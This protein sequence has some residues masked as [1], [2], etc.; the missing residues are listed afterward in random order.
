MDLILLYLLHSTR[1][2]GQQ[3]RKEMRKHGR[4][5]KAD[6]QDED[7]LNHEQQAI[8]LRHLA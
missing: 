5:Y 6:Y 1:S 7:C 4:V 8:E 3:M 2:F